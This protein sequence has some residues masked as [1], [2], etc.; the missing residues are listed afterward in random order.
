MRGLSIAAMFCVVSSSAYADEVPRKFEVTVTLKGAAPT[1]DTVV[2]EGRVLKMQTLKSLGVDVV[3][4]TTKAVSKRTRY[5]FK[6][7][8]RAWSCST[9]C[10]TRRASSLGTS[11][12]AAQT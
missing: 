2:L 11:P 6:A 5:E 4:V 7:E 9:G 8:A 12:T 10:S 3:D 1:G